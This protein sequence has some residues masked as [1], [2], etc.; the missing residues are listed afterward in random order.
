MEKYLTF[1]DLLPCVCSC[2]EHLINNSD[3]HDIWSIYCGDINC[4]KIYASVDVDWN[5]IPGTID[6]LVRKYNE[7]VVKWICE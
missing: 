7:N 5:D 6:R 3:L 1:K 4:N 2:N